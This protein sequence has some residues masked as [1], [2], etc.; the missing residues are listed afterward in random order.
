M[1][2]RGATA[3]ALLAVTAACGSHDP[4]VDANSVPTYCN[5]AQAHKGESITNV[6]KELLKVAP[7]KDLKADIRAV[8]A[9]NDPQ[10]KH[11]EHVRTFTHDNCQ[12]DL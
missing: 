8:L 4:K 12:V 2:I 7:G 3:A 10:Q 6:F 9:V 5:V 11:F 1:R